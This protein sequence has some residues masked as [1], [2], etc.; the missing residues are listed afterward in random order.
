MITQNNELELF[1]NFQAHSVRVDTNGLA[2]LLFFPPPSTLPHSFLSAPLSLFLSARRSLPLYYPP[3][4]FLPHRRLFFSRLS[5]M[6]T[7]ND[8]DSA[9]AKIYM[10]IRRIAPFY[11]IIHA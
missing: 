2:F 3:S 6:V 10:V 8:P 1:E 4:S 9:R 7:T 5:Q 11:V